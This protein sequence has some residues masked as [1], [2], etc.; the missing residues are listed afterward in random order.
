MQQTTHNLSHKK[1]RKAFGKS[2]R[3]KSNNLQTA[4]EVNRLLKEKETI[5]ERKKNSMVKNIRELF[6]EK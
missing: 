3:N 1:H 5:K 2:N 6:T 4:R